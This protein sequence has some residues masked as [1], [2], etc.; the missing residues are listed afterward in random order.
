MAH[1]LKPI[2]ATFLSLN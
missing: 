2:G 1:E